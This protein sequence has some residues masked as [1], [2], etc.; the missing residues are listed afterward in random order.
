MVKKWVA[1]N[2]LFII[3]VVIWS[4]QKETISVEILMAKTLSQISLIFFLANINLYFVFLIIRKNKNKQVKK[5][6]AKMSRKAMK[7]H[8][9]IAL[10]GT[11]LILIHAV[12]MLLNHP[13]EL[14]SLKKIS[15][16]M[17]FLVLLVLLFSGL[18]RRW[19]ASGFRR[20]FHITMAF[21]FLFFFVIH[22]FN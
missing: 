13:V 21:T 8:I 5:T 9:P 6:L 2:I 17:A 19:R 15:G 20:K 12:M 4:W 18:L 3:A 10:T 16:F 1:V 14:L 11:S 7:I 22:I